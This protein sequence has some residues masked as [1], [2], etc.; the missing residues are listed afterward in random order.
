MANI[1]L[2]IG[3]PRTATSSLQH[4]LA[5]NPG[6]LADAGF[7][8]PT[9]CRGG[10]AH[11]PLA[12]D[13]MEATLGQHM[14]DYWY[15]ATERGT[16]WQK[17][18]EELGGLSSDTKII[19]STELFFAQ[20]EAFV[21]ALQQMASSLAHHTVYVVV[22]LRRQDRIFSSFYNQDVKG[23]RRWAH[24]AYRFYHTHKLFEKSYHDRLRLWA[25]VFGRERLIVRPFEKEQWSGGS[26]VSDFCTAVGLGSLHG[27]FAEHNAS[28]GMVQLHVK[29]CLNKTG[30]TAE[31]NAEAVGLL[32]EL[33]P[34]ESIP[35]VRYVSAGKYDKL[36]ADWRADN[37][38]VSSEYLDGNPLFHDPI[39]L[40]NDVDFYTVPK[41]GLA[42]YLELMLRHFSEG[43]SPELRPLF[44]R[45]TLLA[46]ADLNLWIVAEDGKAETL[47]EWAAL[48][49]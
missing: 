9:S 47:I 21:P 43:G 27:E 36:A 14:A 8:Y 23:T 13:L 25:S 35:Q 41:F 44:A 7:T 15:G 40:A 17:L 31:Q 16:A 30:I 26:V 29:R 3:A 2:H 6:A 34:G 22:Y 38:L 46:I 4:L 11:H 49:S 1:Y 37:A 5:T 32:Q 33:C 45:A 24:D 48:G 28:L 18:E 10:D 12:C 39:P 20:G 42:V 19:L